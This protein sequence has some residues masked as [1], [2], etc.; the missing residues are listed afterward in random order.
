MAMLKRIL[1]GSALLAAASLAPYWIASA[2]AG[3]GVAQFDGTWSVSIVTDSG[4][5]D[6]GY[7]YALHIANGRIFYDNPSFNVNGQVNA[8]GQVS[9]TVSAGGQSA[10]G[11]G[12]LSR[13]YGTG[14]WIGRSASDQCSGHW[15]AERRAGAGY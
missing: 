3:P 4:S 5:C 12:R 8:R 11:V 10:S 6:R 1:L 2:A 9:V 13:D 14:T 7:R 15:E